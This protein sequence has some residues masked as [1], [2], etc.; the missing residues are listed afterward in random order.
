MCF[1]K[2]TAVISPFLAL[3]QSHA[4]LT[5]TGTHFCSHFVC[6]SPPLPPAS[7]PL[8][9]APAASPEPSPPLL[10]RD[11]P[12]LDIA[13]APLAPLVTT[14]RPTPWSRK[15]EAASPTSE[16]PEML[17]ASSC[18]RA[19]ERKEASATDWNGTGG[20]EGFGLRGLGP[21]G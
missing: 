13:N 21:T 5:S 15:N 1:V 17:S 20:G 11:L 18:A 14:T 2:R 9:V 4:S 7:S 3:C 19:V 8:L 10:P 16:Q 12:A 6:T